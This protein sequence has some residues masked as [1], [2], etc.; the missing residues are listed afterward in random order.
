MIGF[1]KK[2][3]G[4][5]LKYRKLL[6]GSKKTTVYPYVIQGRQDTTTMAEFTVTVYYTKTFKENTADPHTFIDQVSYPSSQRLFY[7]TK[8]RTGLNHSCSNN[9]L[10]GRLTRRDFP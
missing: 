1:R 8:V 5:L 10:R 9:P 4:F 7:L 6:V 2:N 3:P